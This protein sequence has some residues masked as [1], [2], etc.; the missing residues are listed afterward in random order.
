M[1]F[2]KRKSD[3]FDPDIDTNPLKVPI[4]AWTVGIDPSTGF[5]MY[6]VGLA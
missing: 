5:P 4:V 1:R 2:F 6:S 3:L